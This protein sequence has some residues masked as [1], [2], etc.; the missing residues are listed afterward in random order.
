[1]RPTTISNVLLFCICWLPLSQA[2]CNCSAPTLASS[3]QAST[4]VIKAL[5][6]GNEPSANGNRFYDARVQTVYKGCDVK[7]N[8]N[9]VLTT[10]ATAASCGVF[11]DT[12]TEY[13]LMGDVDHVLEVFS[14]N[15]VR[16]IVYIS[17]SKCRFRARYI[18]LNAYQ[19]QHLKQ[20]QA[21]VPPCV[22]PTPVVCNKTSCGI[23]NLPNIALCPGQNASFNRVKCTYLNSTKKCGY[24]ILPCPAPPPTPSVKCNATSCGIANLPNLPLC[25]G[26]TGTLNRVKCT[27]LNSTGHCG[28]EI[29]PCP[30][31]PPVKC[32]STSCGIEFL[33]NIRPC[34]GQKGILNRTKCTYLNSTG[35]CGYEILPCPAH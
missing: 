11:L 31:P 30:S 2:T 25:P 7:P 3:F 10:K 27:Y 4:I 8:Q 21:T 23:A 17:V 20:L 19:V 29:L 13:V 18:T 1:M 28:Y 26:Q 34:P 9:V 24:V 35:R 22:G 14:T 32:N 16:Q 15:G 6:T 12:A 5:V 33:P